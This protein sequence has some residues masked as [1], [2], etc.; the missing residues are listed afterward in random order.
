M[1]LVLLL[2]QLFDS[3]VPAHLMGDRRRVWESKE[4]ERVRKSK[5]ELAI[6]LAFVDLRQN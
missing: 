6:R 1:V 4:R 2:C 5:S 3:H